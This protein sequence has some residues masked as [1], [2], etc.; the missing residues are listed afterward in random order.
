MLPK[1]LSVIDLSIG[2]SG[3]HIEI[4]GY[5]EGYWRTLIKLT[6]LEL[7]LLPDFH[8][9]DDSRSFIIRNGKRKLT[10]IFYPKFS[11]YRLSLLTYSCV[12]FITKQTT[13]FSSAEYTTVREFA[14][15]VDAAECCNNPSDY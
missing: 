5:Q 11:Q 13:L 8:K 10:I 3:G 7:I 15:R 6:S 1:E 14:K 12:K 9:A 4:R 2:H